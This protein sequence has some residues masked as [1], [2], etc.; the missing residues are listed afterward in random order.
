MAFNR[1]PGASTLTFWEDLSSGQLT[2][3]EWRVGD[4]V[5]DMVG[6]RK[7]RPRG[8]LSYHG[9]SRPEAGVP[10]PMLVYYLSRYTREFRRVAG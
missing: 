10:G 9:D 8:S 5:R 2:G 7:E 3:R 4:R 6:R 1:R